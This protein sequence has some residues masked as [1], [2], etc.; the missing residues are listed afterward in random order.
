MDEIQTD[1]NGHKDV[2]TLPPLKLGNG[3]EWRIPA[4]LAAAFIR[5]VYDKYPQQAGNAM[6][7]AMTGSE[8]P[9]GG[10]RTTKAGE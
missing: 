8:L 3:P 9:T 5:A 4:E 6:H 1:S 7:L 2:R 10:R